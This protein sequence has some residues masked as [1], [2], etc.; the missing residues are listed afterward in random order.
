MWENKDVKINPE[1]IRLV[2]YWIKDWHMQWEKM[3]TELIQWTF[4][5]HDYLR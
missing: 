3:I 5:K 2:V 1:D 4:N